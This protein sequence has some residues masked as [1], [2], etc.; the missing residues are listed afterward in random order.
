MAK[1]YI[2]G[3]V[4]FKSHDFSW[5][6]CCNRDVL[7]L[8]YCWTQSYSVILIAIECVVDKNIVVF[9][10]KIILRMVKCRFMNEK[11]EKIGGTG[12]IVEVVETQIF[13][14]KYTF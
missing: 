4:L 1:N 7:K 5:Y 11:V 9:R 12:H 14:R 13:K 6:S 2:E 10:F 3:R 8:S